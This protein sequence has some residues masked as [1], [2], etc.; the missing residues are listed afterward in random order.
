MS[1]TTCVSVFLPAFPRSLTHTRGICQ[2]LVCFVRER[3]EVNHDVSE[4]R[5][6]SRDVRVMCQES[7]IEETLESWVKSRLFKSCPLNLRSTISS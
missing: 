3:R 4:V 7:S 6:S 5:R 1:F 2:V